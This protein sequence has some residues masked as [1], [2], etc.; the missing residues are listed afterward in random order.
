MNAITPPTAVPAAQPL[1]CAPAADTAPAILVAA[2]LLLPRLERGERVDAAT[3]R[4]V[5]EAAFGASDA[6]GAWDWKL[7]YEAGEAATVLF[8][9]KYGRALFRAAPSPSGRLSLLSKIAGLLPAHT[10]RSE[11]AQARQQFSTPSPLGLAA[12]TAAAITPA[13]RVLEPSAGTGLLAI[14]AEIAGGALTLNEL[15]ETRAGLLASLFPAIPVTRF[16]AA[17]IDDYLYPSV[18]PTVVLMNPPFSALANVSGRVSDA[19]LRHVG[20]ALARLAPGGRLVAITGAGFS[21]EAPAWRDAFVRLQAQGTVVFTAAVDGTV[22]ARHGTTIDTRLTVID[23]RPAED[24]SLFPASAGTAPDVAT[25]LAWIVAFVPPRLP[26]KGPPSSPRQSAG[27][28]RPAVGRSVH[29]PL[30]RAT[31]PARAPKLFEPEGVSLEYETVDWQPAEGGRLTEALYEPYAL[32]TILILGAE[33]HP[34]KLVQSAA[35]A[36]VAPPKPS[37]RPMPPANVVA[38]GLLSDAQLETVIYAGEAHAAHLAGSWTVDQTFDT[39]TAAPDAANAVRF[40]RG[41]MLGD[42]TGTGKGRQVAGILLDN[43]L[44]GRRKAV[45]VSKSDT[46]IEDAQRDWSALGQERLLVTPLSRFTQGKPITLQEGILFT[47]YATLRSDERGEKISRVRQIVDWLGVGFDG[48]IVFDESHAMQNAAGGKGERG[49][50][51]ASQQG[52][53]GLRLQHALPDARVLYVSATGATTVHNLAYA[54]RLGLWG[55]SDFPF[56]TR[57]EFVQAIEAGGVAAMEVLARDLRTLG[58]YTAR[59]LSYEGVAY[60]LVEHALTPEQTAIYDAYAGAFAIIHTHLDAAM[61]AANITGASGTLNRQAKSAARSA[62]ES[63]KQRF[64]GHL[65]TSMKTPS[66]IRAIE[67]DLAAGHAAVIQIVSTGEALTER[68]LAEIPTEEWSDVRVDVTPRGYVLGYLQHAFPVQ[69]YEPFTDGEGNLSSRPVTRDGQP[70]LCREAVARRDALIER[71]AALDAVPG[72][73][74]AIVQHFGTENVAEVT[75]RSRRIVRKRGGDGIDRLAVESR[76]GGANLAETAAFMDDLKRILVFSDAG[77][78]GRSYHADLAAKNQR[79]RVH[80][81]V[82]PGWKADAAIQGLGRTN[83][84]NQ[85]QPPLF[86]PVATDVKAEKRFLSTIARRLDTLGAITRGARQTGGQ[87]LFRPEDNLESVY[88]RDA[89]RQL[90][91]LLVLGKVEGCSLDTFEAAT[92]LK[93]TGETGGLLDELPPITTF[94]NRLLALTI[95]LQG[96]LFEAFEG[97]LAARIE[98]AIASGSY[99]VGLET[100]QAESFTVTDTQV[101]H[102]HPGTGAE[103]RLLTITRRDRNRPV[104]LA[105]ALERLDDPRARL[106]RNDRSG[107]AAVQVP[108]PGMMLDDG[109]IERRVRLIRPMETQRLPER[110]MAETHWI[111]AGPE[112]FATTWE[113]ELAEVPPFTDSN[114]HMVAGLLLPIWKR[115]PAESTRVYRLQI[116]AGARLIGR[117]VSPAWA[118]AALAN[119]GGI[120]L[121]AD[122]A[123][124]ALVEGRTMLDLADGLQL[125]RAR[126]MNAHRIELLG[127]TEPMR[128]R[129]RAH[130]LFGEIISWRLRFFVPVDSGGVAVLARLLAAHPIARIGEREAA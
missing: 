55:G 36:S 112:A 46:L 121:S 103:T 40:R 93:L 118:A 80:Y 12:L 42:G 38:D 22:Y 123:H 97:L 83:R 104:T 10:R 48:V 122:A 49:D 101:I 24:P 105:G 58:L 11:E 74:D 4:D 128:E 35:M 16:D 50:V 127:F 69:L 125:R 129:L 28:V 107:R 61:R 67:R 39:V 72:A 70:V 45:W 23:K 7:A 78:T 73:L 29:T 77:G 18:I 56:A 54:P 110:M 21:P 126:V 26:L 96:V 79:L 34:T 65:L 15:A 3:L 27:G 5:M 92:G 100:L 114:L 117:R 102:V 98:G 52:R 124:A 59:S 62:F 31:A 63:T 94:L 91:G 64:F 81:L 32:Q 90:Y 82:E 84:T 17:Q 86:R 9:R 25:L 89:L 60:E 13:D 99:D 66:L 68:R 95:A 57:T 76:A 47:T 51:A 71:L 20:S 120:I 88:A 119:E 116:D 109:S 111:E 2:S 1:P 75:G 87:G 44:S 37:H 30:P 19:A 8:L 130:G 53:A 14:L 85:A 41:F 6:D 115:L 33:P 43:W 106:L 108:S 113:A